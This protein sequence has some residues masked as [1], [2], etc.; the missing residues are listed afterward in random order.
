MY[1]RPV[2]RWLPAAL[3]CVLLAMPL[4]AALPTP[5]IVRGEEPAG[6]TLAQQLRYIGRDGTTRMPATVNDRFIA[7]VERSY[8][9]YG[10][11]EFKAV[12]PPPAAGVDVARLAIPAIGVD[13]PV[14]R[15]GLDRYGRLDVPQETTTVGWNP[16]FN[17]LPGTGG[18]T[19]FAAHYTFG[20]RA[21]VF[22]RLSSLKGGDTIRVTL[23]DG[24]TH[25]YRVTSVID[26]VLESIDMGALLAGREGVESITL[27]TCS[28]P[29]T[30]HG[31]AMRTVVLAERID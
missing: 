10:I 14:G 26:Y 28:G 25:E 3:G 29:I 8:A 12:P 22:Y 21:G 1:T 7:E 4:A 13:A 11:E 17:A 19:F 9:M 20:G 5:S 30:P 15:Y 18:A 16:A 2:R 31:N 27:M 6:T 23:S 24:S